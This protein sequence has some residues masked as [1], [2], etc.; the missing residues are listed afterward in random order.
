[1]MT[2]FRKSARFQLVVAGLTALAV[3]G[4]FVTTGNALASSAG[5]A[6]MALLGFQALPIPG[7]RRPPTI[8]D[9]RDEAIQRR[10]YSAG[11][12][13]LWAFLVAWGVI[14]PLAFSEGGEVPLALVAPVIWVAWWLL[15]VVR[16]LT[17]LVL[18][19]RGF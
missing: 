16:S 3:G 2:E 15:T 9:E 11:Y 7:R 6:V 4:V 19:S 13:A 8:Q 14:V 5:F 10:A 1:M 18:D 17:I 12:T